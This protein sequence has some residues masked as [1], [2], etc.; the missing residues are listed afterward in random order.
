[1]KKRTIL[2]ILCLSAG[3][4][5]EI[6][7]YIIQNFN[8]IAIGLLLIFVNNILFAVKNIK[9]HIYFLIFQ[10]TFFVFILSRPILGA[11][12]REEWW[13]T[14]YQAEENIYFALFVVTLAMLSLYIGGQIGCSLYKVKSMPRFKDYNMT[15]KDQVWWIQKVSRIVFFVTAFFFFLQEG[16]KMMFMSG[17]T[18]VEFYSEFT[19][20]LPGFFHT[21]ASF[22]TYSLCV[23]LA[24]FPDKKKCFLP[25]AIF[26]VSAI[27]SLI[28]GMRNP[29]VLNSLFIFFYYFMR[30]VKRERQER[31][32]IGKIEKRIICLLSPFAILF[33]AVYSYV[34]VGKSLVTKNPFLLIVNFLYGQGV[35]FDVITIGYGWQLGLPQRAGRNYTFGGMIDYITRGRIGQFLF[36]TQPLPEG[37]NLINAIES[38]S[39]A[40]NLSYVSK[41][42]AYLEG[43]G[44]GSS[45][46][47]ENYLDFGYIGVICVS[48]ILGV[49]L[50]SAMNWWGDKI[51]LN[52]VILVSLTGIFFIPRAE[53]TGWLTFIITAR[54]WSCIVLIYFVA[55]LSKWIYQKRK[56]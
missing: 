46:V 8:I 45:Y 34:R 49:V 38:N 43:Y 30:D 42:E 25:L 36:H 16:E 56:G 22:M 20:K 15:I 47:L 12:K 17:R 14:A 55:Y 4:S 13:K 27:P 33:M 7:G 48:L 41:K 40:H 26:E 21:I 2:G 9:G 39:L 5:I 23:Y 44:W 18:Y 29:I 52:T 51:I 28:V 1:M 35:T 37:N 3:L 10:L 11:L 6:L 53:T 24:T 31:K 19:S 50:V 32:W 54:F